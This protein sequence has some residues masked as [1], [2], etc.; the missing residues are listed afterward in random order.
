[1]RPPPTSAPPT[2]TWVA[3]APAFT[4]SAMHWR[5]LGFCC[6]RGPGLLALG[7]WPGFPPPPPPSPKPNESAPLPPP[8]PPPPQSPVRHA[9]TSTAPSHGD[10]GS[11]GS[12]SR[13]S[14]SE[15]FAGSSRSE[16]HT[17]ELQSHSDLVCRLLLGK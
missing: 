3:A 8:P 14:G 15:E 2:K 11:N 1:M 9:K 5:Q 10:G 6:G 16:E 13:P 4:A 12:S 17:S 7:C